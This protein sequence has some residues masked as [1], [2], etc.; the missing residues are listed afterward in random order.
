[1]TMKKPQAVIFDMDGVLVD[2]EP[3]HYENEN[4]MFQKLGLEIPDEEH[5]RFTGVATDLMWEQIIQSRKLNYSVAE[6]TELTIRES[7]GYFQSLEFLEPMPGLVGLLEALMIKKIPLA[8]AS[9]SDAETMRNILEKSGLR[10]YFLFTVS[11]NDVAKSKPAPDV[12]L[13]AARLL[14]VAPENCLVFEDSKNGIKAAKAA[15]MYCIAYSGGNSGHQDQSQADHRIAD[16]NEI[17]IETL[18]K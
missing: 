2:S 7:I 18:L 5:A 16:F 3:F 6:L 17:D 11:R 13:K 8:V 4:R 12:F 9:S 14:G 10:K 15:G 1:M